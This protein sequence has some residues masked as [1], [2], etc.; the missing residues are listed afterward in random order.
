[1]VNYQKILY[2]SGVGYLTVVS[3]DHYI[4]KISFGKGALEPDTQWSKDHDLL[5]QAEIQLMEYLNGTRKVFTLPLKTTGTAFQQAVW[6]ALQQI[7]YGETVTYGQLAQM[8]Q[9]PNAARAVGGGCNKNPIAIMIPCHRVIGA[10]GNLTGF[11][12]G[13]TVKNYLLSLEQKNS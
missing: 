10:N 1:M 13:I 12:G 11:A 6:D 7:P 5:I 2:H 8:I 9:K 3:D 4:R